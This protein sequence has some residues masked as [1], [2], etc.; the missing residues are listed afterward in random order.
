MQKHGRL[1]V[2]PEYGLL[3]LLGQCG[4]IRKAARTAVYGP[5]RIVVWEGEGLVPR[6][7][8]ADKDQLVPGERL[9]AGVLG[10]I[11]DDGLSPLAEGPREILPG[12]G[13]M[14]MLEG[15]VPDIRP[16]QGGDGRVGVIGGLEENDLVTRLDEPEQRCAQPL[17]SPGGDGHLLVRVHLHAIEALHFSGDGLAEGAGAD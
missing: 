6:T 16:G 11:D 8:R 17:G 3:D 4:A 2:R 12:Q 14:G 13:E 1:R 5:V 9:A 7:E 15:H 10:V